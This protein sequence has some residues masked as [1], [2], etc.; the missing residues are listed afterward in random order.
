MSLTL[1]GPVPVGSGGPPTG[2]ATGSGGFGAP[3]AVDGAPAPDDGVV[4]FATG[5]FDLAQAPIVR[6]MVRMTTGA[7]TL[8]LCMLGLSAQCSSGVYPGPRPDYCDQF[9]YLL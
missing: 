7:A 5:G 8:P 1:S 6:A 9:G 3:P 4:G 2:S